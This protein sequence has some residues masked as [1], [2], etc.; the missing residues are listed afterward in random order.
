MKQSSLC[1]GVRG[2]VIVS[3]NWMRLAYLVVDWL[4]QFGGQ[5]VEARIFAG[6]DTLVILISIPLSGSVLEC[7]HLIYNEAKIRHER[8]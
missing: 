8:L 7:T 6:L 4:V 1:P 2:S 3:N 5:T